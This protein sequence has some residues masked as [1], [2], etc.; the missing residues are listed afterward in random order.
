[1]NYWILQANTEYDIEKWLRDI[2]PPEGESLPDCWHIS[3]FFKGQVKPGED[4]AFIW[5]PKGSSQIRG[6]YAKAKVVS[7]PDKCPLED[8]EAD[9]CRSQK[10]KKQMEK[11][12]KLPGQL[13]VTYTHTSLYLDKPLL[14]G[15]IEEV[16]ELRGLTILKKGGACSRGIHKVE[17]GQ[18]RI[19]ESLLCRA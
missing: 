19:I 10:G 4:I 14:S 5:K 6:I 8:K 1:M 15:A 2:T 16:S 12:R 13:A 7:R 18:G 3:R 9:Y 17:P 11:L